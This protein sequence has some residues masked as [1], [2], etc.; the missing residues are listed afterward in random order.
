VDKIEETR[1]KRTEGIQAA[2]T[3]EMIARRAEA[4]RDGWTE[5]KRA[6]FSK[7]MKEQCADPEHLKRRSEAAKAAWAKKKS[8]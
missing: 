4:N 8:G 1:R 6:A 7:Q 2:Q 3:P 5:E